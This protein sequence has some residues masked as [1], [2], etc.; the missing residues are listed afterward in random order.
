MLSG[1]IG[2]LTATVSGD[3]SASILLNGVDVGQSATVVDGDEIE[4]SIHSGINHDDVV[5]ATLDIGGESATWSVT[6]RNDGFFFSFADA[7]GG[8][9]RHILATSDGGWLISGELGES[10]FQNGYALKVDSTFT[11]E[12]DV[13]LDYRQ[14]FY[15]EY[16]REN[17][18]ESF[19]LTGTD[20]NGTDDASS[21]FV[22]IPL[23]Q[24]N[25]E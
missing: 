4:L 19:T 10:D 7:D 16:S 14:I 8:R 13:V 1:F 12:W 20:Y 21:V 23:L 17:L 25:H 24:S 18:D 22:V 3:P 2:S 11:K 6:S 9:P 15:L 5:S